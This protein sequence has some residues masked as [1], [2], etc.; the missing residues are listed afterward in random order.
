MAQIDSGLPLAVAIKFVT[1]NGQP[2]GGHMG[3]VIGYQIDEDG[4]QFVL[5]LDPDGFHGAAILKFKHLFGIAAD[6]SYEHWR[7]YYDIAR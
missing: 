5:A 7:T 4:E 2:A 3:T 1:E 6:G